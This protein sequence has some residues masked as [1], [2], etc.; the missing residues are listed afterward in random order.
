MRQRNDTDY[1]L[2]VGT[3][4]VSLVEAGGEIY[5]EH[6]VAGLTVVDEEPPPAPVDEPAPTKP[7]AARKAT[8][9]PAAK[10]ATQ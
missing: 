2:I 1:D 3:D 4:P 10:E 6:P 9:A 8:A 7:T 5:H